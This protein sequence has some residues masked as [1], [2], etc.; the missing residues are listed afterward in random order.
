MKT[1]G[2]FSLAVM[3]WILNACSNDVDESDAYGNFEATEIIVASET[4]GKITEFNVEEGQKLKKDFLAGLIDT[5]M[6]YLSRQQVI[7]QKKAVST[8]TANILSQIEIQEEQK[9]TLLKEKQR[10]EQLLKDD[11]IAEKQLDDINGKLN[12]IESTIKSI[13]TQNS[14][15]LSELEA[16]NTRVEQLDEQ[17]NKCRIINPIDGI[18]LEKF[19]EVHEIAVPGKPLYKIADMTNMYLRVYVSGAQLPD[20][21]TGQEVEVLIDKDKKTNQSLKGVVSWISQEAEFTPKIIQTKEERVNL[22]YAV[23]VKVKNNGR[24]KIGM[25]GEINFVMR[26]EGRGE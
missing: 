10:V 8:K 9:K 6:L 4:Q 13:K 21:R 20:V 15:V 2:F 7:A 24:L 3:I 16:L 19:V 18:I 11:A 5:T 22:V 25:P 17:L 23:K 14:T 26:N 12:V 1:I